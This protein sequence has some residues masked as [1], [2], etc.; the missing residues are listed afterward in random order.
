MNRQAILAI[1]VL[2]GAILIAVVMVLLRPQPEE[3][4]REAPED[5]PTHHL[6][7]LR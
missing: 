6:H 7:A 4:E 5:H 2:G 3:Q 1:A